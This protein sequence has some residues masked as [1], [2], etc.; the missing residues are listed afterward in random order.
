V[1][2]ERLAQRLL[3]LAIGDRDRREVRFRLDLEVARAEMPQRDR[4]G[5]IRQAE[6]EAKILV[7]LAAGALVIGTRTL[8]G[9]QATGLPP[10]ARGVERGRARSSGALVHQELVSKAHPSSSPRRS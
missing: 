5:A 8:T 7:Q 6:R 9:R 10:W 2:V 4:V 3:R 1:L